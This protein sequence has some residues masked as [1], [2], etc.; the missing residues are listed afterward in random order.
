MNLGRLRMLDEVAR[1]GTLAGAADALSFT[2]AAVSQSMSRLEAEVGAVLL[3]RSSRG[4]QLTE[5]GQVLLGHARRILAEVQAA[6][7]ELGA[8]DDLGAGTLRLGSFP[9][10][11]QTLTARALASFRERHPR[12]VV[13]LVDDEPHNNLARLDEGQLDLALVFAVDDRPLG[14][15]YHGRAVCPAEAVAVEELFHDHYVVVVP[16]D[17]SLGDRPVRIDD[18]RDRPLIGRLAT[19]GMGVLAA[20]CRAHGFE[21]RFNDYYCPDYQGVRALV[22]AGEGLAVVPMMAVVRPLPGVATRRLEDLPLRRRVLLARAA[23]GPLTPAAVE[24][25]RV[26]RAMAAT[27]CVASGRWSLRR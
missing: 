5:A 8:L 25:S 3:V 10:A 13:R 26:L 16:A 17:E 23:G 14:V 9:T 11:T 15:D 20:A 6:E 7:A 22:A 19:P 27:F 1:H 24:M 18:L 2:P 21:P 12:I 4:V